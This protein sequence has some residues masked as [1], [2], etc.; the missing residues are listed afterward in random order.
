MGCRFLLH[1]HTV[2]F[3]N[4]FCKRKIQYKIFKKMFTCSLFSS[5]LFIWKEREGKTHLSSSFRVTKVGTSKPNPKETWMAA[6]S[7]WAQRWMTSG[8]RA[9]AEIP[10]YSILDVCVQVASVTLTLCNPVDYSPQ[11]PVHGI[12]QARILEWVA[13]PSSRGSS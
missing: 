2:P 9:L 5:P 11:A 6:N 7:F 3:C 4:L 8:G 13:V 10:R 12:L 1:G